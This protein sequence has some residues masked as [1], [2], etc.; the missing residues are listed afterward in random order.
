[1][2]LTSAFLNATSPARRV[3]LACACL[4]MAGCSQ[5]FMQTG[6]V[7][8]GSAPIRTGSVSPPT[9]PARYAPPQR[10]APGYSWNGNPA[11]LSYG[12]GSEPAAT[13]AH[14]A[15]RPAAPVA[16]P[17]WHATARPPERVPNTQA[18]NAAPAVNTNMVTVAQGDTL[19]AISRRHGTSVASLMDTNHL[20]SIDVYPGQQLALPTRAR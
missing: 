17:V 1:M 4:L 5:S 9:A 7:D 16:G 2:R 15:A 14:A 11:R 8:S 6:S 18:V 19:Y 13:Q 10:P 3:T 12:Y 20:R